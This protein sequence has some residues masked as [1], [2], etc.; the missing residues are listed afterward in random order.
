MRD[1]DK[2]IRGFRDRCPRLLLVLEGHGDSYLCLFA[3][4]L[5]F[6]RSVALVRSVD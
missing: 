2:A 3:S 5:C 1:G 6:E 4:S